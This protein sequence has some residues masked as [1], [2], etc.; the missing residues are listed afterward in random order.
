MWFFSV[1]LFVC[2]YVLQKPKKSDENTKYTHHEQFFLEPKK[3]PR[4]V[5]SI[6][7]MWFAVVHNKM[8][9]PHLG[10]QIG[11][12]WQTSWISH[13]CVHCVHILRKEHLFD[14]NHVF[15]FPKSNYCYIVFRPFYRCSIFSHQK[16]NEILNFMWSILFSV[17][18]V[19]WIPSIYL[20]ASQ[21]VHPY[22]L[23]GGLWF[24]LHSETKPMGKIAWCKTA[25]IGLGAMLIWKL[26]ENCSAWVN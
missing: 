5:K 12:P 25:R 10:W 20:S 11:D 9:M 19:Q 7:F 1:C 24:W 3:Q 23:F 16:M 22:N 15:G 4:L 13:A 8:S 14:Q 26:L 2:V 17:E 18:H 21:S 6:D